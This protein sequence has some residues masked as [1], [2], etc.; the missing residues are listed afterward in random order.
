M[1]LKRAMIML[2]LLTT[3][4]TSRT[5]VENLQMITIMGGAVRV[6]G[7]VGPSSDIANDV[8]EWNISGKRVIQRPNL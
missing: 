3:L 7:N 1:N 8:A 5:I 6:P 4:S 2:C